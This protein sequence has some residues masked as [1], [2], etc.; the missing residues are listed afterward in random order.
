MTGR[1]TLRHTEARREQS[2]IQLQWQLQIL[3]ARAGHFVSAMG[4]IC[5]FQT[6]SSFLLLAIVL[7]LFLWQAQM[8]LPHQQMEKGKQDIHMHHEIRSSQIFKTTLWACWGNLGFISPCTVPIFPSIYDKGCIF[9]GSSSFFYS[10]PKRSR[11][12]CIIPPARKQ[13]N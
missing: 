6:N 11:L 3:A 12:F 4:I 10:S 13:R 7:S 9:L 5:P 8:C 2:H 1:P